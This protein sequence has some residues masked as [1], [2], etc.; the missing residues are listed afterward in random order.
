[1]STK[2]KIQIEREHGEEN[3]AMRYQGSETKINN[4]NDELPVHPEDGSLCECNGFHYWKDSNGKRA[5]TN[6][7]EGSK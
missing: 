2:T 1:M 4:D 7:T 3:I 6:T 5:F